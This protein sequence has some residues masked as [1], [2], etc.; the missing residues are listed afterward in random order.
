MRAYDG[1]I[2]DFDGTLV[3]TE[4]LY[5]KANYDAFRL[6]GHHIDE[7]EYYY[8]WSLLG[9]GTKGEIERYGLT[10]IDVDAVKSIA[11]KNYRR[12]VQTH[13]IP[14]FSYG[15]ALLTA[16]PAKGFRI[17]I[18]SNTARD[19]IASILTQ[20]GFSDSS[21]TI[22]GGDQYKP[23]PAPDIFLAAQQQLGI[24]KNRCLIL[25]DTD[26]GVKAARAAEIPFAVVHSPLYPDYHPDD[27]VQKFPDLLTFYRFL[28][29][30]DSIP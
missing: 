30:E 19:L 21:I 18:A 4:P 27:A 3:D 13:D 12:L 8:Y 15:K 14:F 5:Y 29:G 16:L 10:S 26:K 25:E 7:R 20:S 28:T 6:Y 9:T 17:I 24:C 1:I 22:L 11:R 23:K 2:F